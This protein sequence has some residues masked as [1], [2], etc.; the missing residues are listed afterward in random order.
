ML[1]QSDVLCMKGDFTGA[2]APYVTK[3]EKIGPETRA[4]DIKNDESDRENTGKSVD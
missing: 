3:T 1:L 4:D 2:L